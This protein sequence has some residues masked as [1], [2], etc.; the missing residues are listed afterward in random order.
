MSCYNVGWVAPG[1]WLAYDVHIARSSRYTFTV[2]AAASRRGTRLH[3]EVNGVDVTGPLQVP[4][5][6]GYQ[7]W[8]DVVSRPVA[9]AAGT[10]ELRVVAE[11]DSLNWNYLVVSHSAP[12]TTLPPAPTPLP[13][14]LATPSPR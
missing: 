7:V 4:Q 13:P 9:L 10:Y 2:R 8:T 11:T 3:L 5:T 12:A 6:G 14:A 1:E